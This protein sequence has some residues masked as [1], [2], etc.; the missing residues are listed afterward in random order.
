MSALRG[1]ALGAIRFYQWFLSPV[2]PGSCRYLP[3]CSA[4]AAEAI[5]RHG[6]ARGLWLGLR[7]LARCNPWGGWGWDPVPEAP[8]KSP[9]CSHAR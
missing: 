6:L 3:S 7:R 5:E 4:Y 2:L 1:A 8:E 9:H